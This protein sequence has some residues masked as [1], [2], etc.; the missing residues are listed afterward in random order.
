[1]THQPALFTEPTPASS[2]PVEC[3]GLT[4]K[5]DAAHRAYFNREAARPRDSL[6]RAV[7]TRQEIA[8]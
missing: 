5:N 2:G 6:N 7:P 1:M 8:T 3:L 4:F